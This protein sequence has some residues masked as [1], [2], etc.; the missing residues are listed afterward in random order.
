MVV[1]VL[2]RVVVER[3]RDDAAH[4]ARGD[5]ARQRTDVGDD[6]RIRGAELG[7][8][9][10]AERVALADGGGVLVH[11]VDV[12][13]HRPRVHVEPAP[14]GG[15]E[16]LG[17]RVTLLDEPAHA[18]LEG[19]APVA[20][21]VRREVANA[22]LEVAHAPARVVR[23][24]VPR[25]VVDGRERDAAEPGPSLDVVEDGLDTLAEKVGREGEDRRLHVRDPRRFIPRRSAGAHWPLRDARPGRRRG[26]AP[27]P[28]MRA[29]A[30]M[31][32]RYGGGIGRVPGTTSPGRRAP[33]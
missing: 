27:A 26:W 6:V 8:L 30:A 7:Q 3:L 23:E 2:E 10:V 33:T 4:T 5:V 28:R 17:Q 12:E 14:A 25:G 9:R 32:A 24:H 13:V 20:T 19:Q 1:A 21:P 16:E 22:V 15:L 11:P 31:Q 29:R 18:R